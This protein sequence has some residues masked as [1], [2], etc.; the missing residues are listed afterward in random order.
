MSYRIQ[1]NP[2]L[3]DVNPVWASFGPDMEGS[4]PTSGGN[5]DGTGWD[6]VID[7][8]QDGVDVVNSVWCLINPSRP[9]CNPNAASNN[10]A[11]QSNPGTSSVP[12]WVWIL[13]ALV[14][15]VLLV[16]LIKK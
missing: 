13:V 1:L 4:Y 5:A 3:A 9:G 2:A 11:N 15:I 10:A 6:R 16:V 7:R 12:Q 14:L 8:T